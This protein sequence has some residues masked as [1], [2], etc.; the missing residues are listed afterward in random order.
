MLPMA[1]TPIET[2]IACGEL[3]PPRGWVSTAYGQREPA[4][5]VTFRAEAPL[6]WRAMT[7][8]V[9]VAGAS[10]EPPAVIEV[11]DAHGRPAGVRFTS[12]LRSV[13]VEDDDIV[14]SS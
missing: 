1:S 14:L 12:T 3:D 5:A 4:P 2:V 10:T 7:L 13:R 9:P 11:R 6:P 8:L